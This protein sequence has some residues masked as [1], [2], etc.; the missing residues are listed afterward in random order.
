MT[1]EGKVFRM[2]KKGEK[3]EVWIIPRII[4]GQARGLKLDTLQGETT[5]PT[6][7][8]VK[9]ALF[10]MIAADLPGCYFADVFAGSGSMGCEALS[11]GAEKVFFIE[12]APECMKVISR[13]VEKVK[14]GQKAQF[15]KESA[16]KALPKLP[17]QDII[18]MDPPYHKNLGILGLEIIAK[19]AILKDD[20]LVILEHDWDEEIPDRI[21]ALACCDT[22][23]YGRCM[24]HFYRWE[25]EVAK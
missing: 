22:R 17:K 1:I 7:D 18:F 4:S 15:Y 24:L 3:W 25:K 11:R 12:E 16:L 9:E 20:G 23:K 10:N 21:G 8:R 5:R 13:N 14:L 6:A 2:E 19:Y